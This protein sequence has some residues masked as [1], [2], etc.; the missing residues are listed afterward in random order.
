[1]YKYT[2]NIILQIKPFSKIKKYIFDFNCREKRLTVLPVSKTCT[3]KFKTSNNI[4]IYSPWQ[5]VCSS[6][7]HSMERLAYS[8]YVLPGGG[9]WEMKTS[10]CLRSKVWNLTSWSNFKMFIYQRSNLFWTAG[11]YCYSWGI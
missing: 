11:F 4:H 2:I 8:S 7:L 3:N 9:C 6:A 10:Y 1:M 5:A